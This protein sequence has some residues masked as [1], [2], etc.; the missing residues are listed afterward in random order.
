MWLFWVLESSCLIG[1]VKR[2]STSTTFLTMYWLDNTFGACYFSGYCTV[3]AR[4]FF[5]FFTF[6]L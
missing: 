1:H 2:C 5:G 6:C 3:G 4:R